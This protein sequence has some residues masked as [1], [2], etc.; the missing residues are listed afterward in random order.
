MES[1]FAVFLALMVACTVGSA[2]GMDHVRREQ[3]EEARVLRAELRRLAEAMA[4]V[5][6]VAIRPARAVPASWTE[7]EV[8]RTAKVDAWAPPQAG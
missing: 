2:L 5:R 4:A 3:R 7:G 6:E 1:Q 8:A